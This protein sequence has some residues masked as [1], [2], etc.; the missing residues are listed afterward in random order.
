M[1][2]CMYAYARRGHLQRSSCSYSFSNDRPLTIPRITVM[3]LYLHIMHAIIWPRLNGRQSLILPITEL[4][5]LVSIME[6]FAELSPSHCSPLLTLSLLLLSLPRRSSEAMAAN[7]CPVTS[8]PD[9]M[10]TTMLS[11]WFDRQTMALILGDQAAK[12]P[13]AAA[14]PVTGSSSSSQDIAESAVKKKKEGIPSLAASRE[15]ETSEP[16]IISLSKQKYLEL[17]LLAPLIWTNIT[18]IDNGDRVGSNTTANPSLETS[19][20][21]GAVCG[22]NSAAETTANKRFIWWWCG[23]YSDSE[24]ARQFF[25]TLCQDIRIWFTFL[26]AYIELLDYFHDFIL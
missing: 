15:Q 20:S 10:E 16:G 21:T 7:P 2:V 3:Q 25:L 26:L 22:T 24:D 6:R 14:G 19:A 13:A 17:L 23:R 1:H 5:P 18:A 11:I 8:A 4:I 9:D 12:D